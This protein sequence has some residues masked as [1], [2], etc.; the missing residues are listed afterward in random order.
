MVE[1]GF[2]KPEV[3]GSNPVSSSI[4]E[5]VELVY[6]TDLKSVGGSSHAGSSPAFATKLI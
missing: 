3:I 2:C 4:G 1:H 5:V 6:T